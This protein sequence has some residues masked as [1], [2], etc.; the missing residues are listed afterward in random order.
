MLVER[1]YFTDFFFLH[2]KIR[3]YIVWIH[4][5]FGDFIDRANKLCFAYFDEVYRWIRN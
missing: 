1:E 4:A 2:Y 5:E 3:G